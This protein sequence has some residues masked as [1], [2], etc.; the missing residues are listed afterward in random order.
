[1]DN[2]TKKLTTATLD[3][4]A[5]SHLTPKRLFSIAEAGTY[6]GCTSIAVREL[7]R[8]GKLKPVRSDA[9]VMLDRHDLDTWIEEG[10]QS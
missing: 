9:R 7:V 1:M 4:V 6:L 8:H 10:K 2:Q 5:T 3:T